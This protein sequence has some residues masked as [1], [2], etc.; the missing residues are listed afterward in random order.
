[1][2]RRTRFLGARRRPRNQL[3][4]VVYY[5]GT[6]ER[7]IQEMVLQIETQWMDLLARGLRQ[8]EDPHRAIEAV[9]RVL[10]RPSNLR[11]VRLIFEIWGASL[12][13]RS[14]RVGVA[15][16]LLTSAALVSKSGSFE[17]R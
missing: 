17:T 5:F 14:R 15:Q 13:E 7:L 6:R 9:W 4:G 11:R 12:H 1:M 2:L 8:S 16:I 3:P 10:C